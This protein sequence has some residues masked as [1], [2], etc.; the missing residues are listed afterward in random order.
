MFVCLWLTLPQWSPR[1]FHGAIFGSVGGGGRQFHFNT[2]RPDADHGA[3]G[4]GLSAHD[5]LH[6]STPPAAPELLRGLGV[7]N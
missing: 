1:L 2:G 3:V 7:S 5:Q 4:G 6:F